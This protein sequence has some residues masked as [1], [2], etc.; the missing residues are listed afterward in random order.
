MTTIIQD[1][2]NEEDDQD[3]LEYLKKEKPNYRALDKKSILALNPLTI[4]V[5]FA[6]TAII[7][8]IL[9]NVEVPNT[10]P[11]C[12]ASLYHR[13]IKKIKLQECSNLN[14]PFFVKPYDNNKSF[15]AVMALYQKMEAV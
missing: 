14:F 7:Q 3:L 6:S 8:K 2:W 12:F 5:L 1:T 4:E 13:N 15:M 9:P 10:Y 11:D